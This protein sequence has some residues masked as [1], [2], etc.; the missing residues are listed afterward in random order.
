[1]A[2]PVKPENGPSVPKLGGFRSDSGFFWGQ[3]VPASFRRSRA[4]G[5]WIFGPLGEKSC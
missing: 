1:M 4:V 2:V 3:F 5:R